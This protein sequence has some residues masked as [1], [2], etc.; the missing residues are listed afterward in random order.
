MSLCHRP[1]P[2]LANVPSPASLSKYSP[3][4]LTDQALKSQWA[5]PIGTACRPNTVPKWL[6]FFSSK[7]NA[8]GGQSCT[9]FSISLKHVL[10]SKH[11]TSKLLYLLSSCR[12]QTVLLPVEPGPFLGCPS[13][14]SCPKLGP[15]H[16]C[17]QHTS[18]A[19]HTAALASLAGR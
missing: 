6:A 15:A 4:P 13:F 18:H 12:L 7:M 8:F 3:Y 17:S 19:A 14:W 16:L 9:L 1:I 5:P 11:Q 2:F 10:C